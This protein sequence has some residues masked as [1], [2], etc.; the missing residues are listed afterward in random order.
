MH[1]SRLSSA[2]CVMRSSISG[3]AASA[4]MFSSCSVRPNESVL[5]FLRHQQPRIRDIERAAEIHAHPDRPRQQRE[6]EREPGGN[7]VEQRE[8]VVPLAVDLVDEGDD[9][10]VAQ[11]AD[12]EQ[13]A[14]LA[15]DAFRGIDHHDRGVDRAQRAVGVLGEVRMARRI[16]QVEHHAVVLERHHRRGD[17]D[18][19]RLLDLEPVGARAPRIAARPHLPRHLDRAAELQQLLGQR[20]LAGVRVR[21]DRERPPRRR[22]RLRGPGGG[23]WNCEASSIG[24]SLKA[25]QRRRERA[26]FRSQRMSEKLYGNVGRAGPV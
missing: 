22:K 24:N 8:R 19:A 4:W 2:G 18:A 7:L 23:Q 26:R 6:I 14:R 16:E 15:L 1:S 10:D 3:Y 13:L 25:D 20:G 11:P 9:R 17:R 12:L 5:H 21:N